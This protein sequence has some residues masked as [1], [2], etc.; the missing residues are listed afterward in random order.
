MLNSALGIFFYLL[1]PNHWSWNLLSSS[2]KD[3]ILDSCYRHNTT[4]CAYP[5]E[6]DREHGR[7][8]SPESTKEGKLLQYALEKY[9]P[10]SV[11]EFG[12]GSGFYT[13]Q[14][15]SFPS[16]KRYHAIDIVQPCIEY[17][18]AQVA[19]KQEDVK[20]SFI[21]GDFLKYEFN[22]KYDLI[23]FVSTLH[24]IPNR[25]D[26]LAKCLSLLSHSGVVVA[27]EPAHNIVRILRLIWRFYKKYHKRSF[28]R[29]R[30]NL[31]T[32]H[33]MTML[34]MNYIRKKCNMK[35]NEIISF[36]FPGERFA[37]F[38][39]GSEFGFGVCRRPSAISMFTNQI[40]I[41]FS[42]NSE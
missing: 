33:F 31:S 18:K 28:W 5:A 39:V 15:L 10:S 13:R 27:I 12:P 22:H 21:C 34:E 1:L 26:Y 38:A 6:Y 8:S 7:K 4:Q 40:Y 16:V 41:S 35:I 14:V 3:I 29:N 20:S 37:P 25:A 32:H 19:A 11:L 42:R 30:D 17:V 9:S 24:H 23:L 2:E 36:S